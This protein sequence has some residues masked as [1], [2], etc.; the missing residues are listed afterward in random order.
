M[1]LV[2]GDRAWGYSTE[3]GRWALQKLSSIADP[4]IVGQDLAVV[5]DGSHVH[6]FSGVTGTW[7]SIPRQENAARKKGELQSVGTPLVG[8]QLVGYQDDSRVYAFSALTG[9]WDSLLHQE[10]ADVTVGLHRVT[11]QFGTTI[12]IFSTKTGRWDSIDWKAKTE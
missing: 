6:A 10:T 2:E 8:T 9:K 4:P 7:D 12:A 3:T 11:A 5:S 1:L